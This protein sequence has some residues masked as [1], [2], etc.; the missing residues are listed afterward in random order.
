MVSHCKRVVQQRGIH[1]QPEPNL[2]HLIA[3]LEGGIKGNRKWGYSF[4]CWRKYRMIFMWVI[5]G[6][7]HILL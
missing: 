6:N 3:H 2:V 1:R 4:F 7:L 5:E